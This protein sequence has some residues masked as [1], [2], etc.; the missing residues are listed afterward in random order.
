MTAPS[1]TAGRS[2]PRFL[3][4]APRWIGGVMGKGDVRSEPSAGES[5]DLSS[6]KK[7]DLLSLGTPIA[8]GDR[9]LRYY[10]QPLKCFRGHVDGVI[11]WLRDTV[12]KVY[13]GTELAAGKTREQMIRSLALDDDQ[14]RERVIDTDYL[15]LIEG[16][17]VRED[18]GGMV[19]GKIL[20]VDGVDHVFKMTTAMIRSE[21]RG[22]KIPLALSYQ[23]LLMTARNI[24]RSNGV[25]R[26]L[27]QLVFRGIPFYATTQSLRVVKDMMLLK[28]LS[29]LRTVR[30]DALT[31]EQKRI[32]AAGARG[33]IDLETGI[34]KE[35]YGGRIAIDREEDKILLQREDQSIRAFMA[36]I[37]DRDRLHL[38]GNVTLGVVLT[39][40]LKLRLAGLAGKYR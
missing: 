29:L 2:T 28:D 37:G 1:R 39:V 19:S 34:E 25:L 20:S 31:D 11:E 21:A 12:L 18:L 17:S 33:Q 27:F 32:F 36:G 13:E 5:S 8:V 30:G 6:Q 40:G 15:Y 35:A 38:T 10:E 7:R 22:R 3:N 26:G 24:L 23:M 16:A 9:M 4:A 14:L